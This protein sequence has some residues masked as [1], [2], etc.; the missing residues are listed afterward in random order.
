M[1][2]WLK[3]NER[4][5]SFINVSTPLNKSCVILN[6][7]LWQELDMIMSPIDAFVRQTFPVLS[8]NL[9]FIFFRWQL[10]PKKAA[11]ICVGLGRGS[12]TSWRQILFSMRCSG[13]SLAKTSP[14][15]CTLWM[16]QRSVTRSGVALVDVMFWGQSRTKNKSLLF[17]VDN[18]VL[19]VFLCV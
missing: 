9:G 16:T 2:Q 8:Q 5:N 1:F 18:S 7:P 15:S 12:P 14:T 10:W 6:N 3:I 4:I 17:A 13:T 11:S 19:C